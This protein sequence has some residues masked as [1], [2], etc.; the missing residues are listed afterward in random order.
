MGTSISL[1]PGW[2]VHPVVFVPLVAEP[3]LDSILAI[4]LL[5]KTMPVVRAWGMHD[6]LR[7]QVTTVCERLDD[8]D[9]R[10]RGPR[11]QRLACHGGWSQRTNRARRDAG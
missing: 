1:G 7:S 3:F 10:S 8:F 11:F 9:F 5:S 6:G 4:L 2:I